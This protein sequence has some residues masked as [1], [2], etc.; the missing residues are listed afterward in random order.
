MSERE[1]IGDSARQHETMTRW[2]WVTK[3]LRQR[4][5]PECDWCLSR[6]QRWAYT[7]KAVLLLVVGR[8]TRLTWRD[9][10]IEVA[11]ANGRSWAGA[12][13]TMHEWDAL[14]VLHGWRPSTWRIATYTEGA[15]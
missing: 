9:A 2:R 1:V 10:R 11:Y 4:C 3:A 7:A 6:W 14:A 5:Q 8:K 12:E 13:M 15:P